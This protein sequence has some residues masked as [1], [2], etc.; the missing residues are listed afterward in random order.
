MY[1]IGGFGFFISFWF[2]L[3]DCVKKNYV[4]I[5]YINKTLDTKW[6]IYEWLKMNCNINLDRMT[7][8]NWDSKLHNL[9]VEI[10]LINS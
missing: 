4:W 5:K 1:V 9:F 3:D 2:N 7:F 8:K 10:C 6:L